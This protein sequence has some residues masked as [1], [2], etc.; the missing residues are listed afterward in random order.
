MPMYAFGIVSLI[1]QLAILRSHRCG[2]LMMLFAESP[3]LVICLGPN[4][5][6]FLS[7]VKTCLIVKLQH[8][9][10]AKAVSETGV[11]IITDVGKPHLASALG[12]DEFLCVQN[13]VSSWVGEMEKF[14]EIAITQLQTMK[15]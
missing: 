15:S 2:M 5:G 6:Y 12:T 14:S 3:L 11:V 1:H 13:K 4:F 7:A 9:H 10:R 8:L